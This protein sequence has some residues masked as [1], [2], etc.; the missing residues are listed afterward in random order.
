M[1]LTVSQ[2]LST[3]F[4]H[5]IIQRSVVQVTTDYSKQNLSVIKPLT[6]IYACPVD[7]WEHTHYVISDHTI[8]CE[9]SILISTVNSLRP[10]YAIPPPHTSHQP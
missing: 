2:Y 1:Y 9:A 3:D 5:C 7:I 6:N 10:H 4:V 8:Y